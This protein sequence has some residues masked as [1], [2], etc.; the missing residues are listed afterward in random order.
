MGTFKSVDQFRTS[1]KRARID[2]KPDCFPLSGEVRRL[3]D[4]VDSD[5]LS[6]GCPFCFLCS[7]CCRCLNA[8]PMSAPFRFFAI[9]PPG[10]EPVAAA[11]LEALSAHDV[12]VEEGGVSF[13]GSLAVLYRVS[14]RARSITR[15]LLRIHSFKALSFPELYNKVKRIDW[16]RYLKS[17]A[18]I[19]VSASCHGSK[20]IHSG[21]AEDSTAE[22]ITARLGGSGKTAKDNQQV[23]LRIDRDIC[24][25][26]LDCSGERLDRR[27]WR[28]EPGL[29]PV[30]ETIAA[31]L[32]QWLGWQSDEP[33]MVPMCGSGT[34][35]IEAACMAARLPAGA[36]HDFPFFRWRNFRQKEWQKVAERA[37]SMAASASEPSIFAS[38]V[39]A[40][41]VAISRR[42]AER[43]G[44][45]GLIAFSQQDV[46][47][48]APLAAG[49]L[50]ILNPPYGERIGDD[51]TAL[52]RE[53]GRRFAQ[54]FAGWRMA[55]FSPGKAC[56][57][58]LGLRPEK[59]LKIRHGGRWLEV[60]Y[61]GDQT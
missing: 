7:E 20:L 56:E 58:A 24:T 53:I 40:E 57:K 35:A 42:N 18:A 28:T 21:R 15:I 60:L 5:K 14:L 22:A 29:A 49:G 31:G 39:D 11:E 9:V 54:E 37:Q 19:A 17:D 30:R 59:R 44:I 1:H 25:V 6:V 2:P 43:A 8:Q 13:S 23:Y 36:D 52:Y 61:I 32:L 47:K 27:G 46:R 38:D 10:F 51:V 12:K 41:A 4:G 55:I 50:L 45:E 48:L 33:L 26:S 34:I 16:S 3:G